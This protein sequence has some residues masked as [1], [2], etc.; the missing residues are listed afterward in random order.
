MVAEKFSGKERRREEEI[1]RREV[2]RHPRSKAASGQ[3][4]V[5]P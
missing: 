4:S 5:T 1:C 3:E 2:M